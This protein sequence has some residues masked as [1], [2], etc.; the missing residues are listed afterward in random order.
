MSD[1]AIPPSPRPDLLL[2]S[3][4]EL[5]AE[6]MI[7][8]RDVARRLVEDDGVVVGT[9]DDG[10]PRPLELDPLPLV[11]GAAE[12]SLLE[13]GLE[14]RAVLLDALLAD[15]YGDRALV[16][17]GLVPAELVIGHPGFLPQADGIPTRHKLFLT[18]ADLGRAAD[19]SWRV[20][21]DRTQAPVGAGYAMATRRII[22]RTL[23]APHRENDL[24]RLRGF[25]DV[26]RAGFLEAASDVV[27]APRV[28]LLASPESAESA[29]D[30]VITATLLGFPLVGAEDLA[31]RR[32]RLWLNTT[33]KPEPVDVV[34]RRV[35]ATVSD[36]L[37]LTGGGGGVPGLVE[38]TR[39]G[40]VT[41]VNPIGAGVLENPALAAYLP[42]IAES[43]LG[44]ELLLP[45]VGTWWCGDPAS[46]AYVRDHLDEPGEL[47][48]R[49]VAGQEGGARVRPAA[50]AAAD[51]EALIARIDA[52]PWAWCAQEVLP[53][54]AISRVTD[55][56]LEQ[57]PALLR[58]FTLAGPR[59]ATTMPGGLARLAPETSPVPTLA[60][61]VAKDVW[62]LRDD[63]AESAEGTPSASD[64]AE[65]TRIVVAMPRDGRP[66]T[67]LPLPPQAAEDLYWFGRY[68]ERAEST[69]R[70]LLVADD[71]VED[72]LRRRG[73]AGHVAMR[74]LIDAIDGVTSVHRDR[75]STPE[76]AD[77]AR[78]WS[79]GA[80]LPHLRGL[81]F[82]ARRRGTVRY[83]ARRAARAAA[84]VRE[85]LSGDT[86]LVLSRLERTLGTPKSIGDDL[87]SVLASVVESLLAL[88]GIAA[89]GLVRDASW[90]FFDAGR[91]VERSQETVRVLRATVTTP[92]PP[93]ADRLV[94]EA[95][96]SSRESIIS[97][98]RRLVEG[99]PRRLPLAVALDLLLTDPTNPR[100]VR[101]QLDRLREDLRHAPAPAVFAALDEVDAH[102]TAADWASTLDDR[103]QLADDLQTLE[104]GLRD[105][106]AA[107]DR[108][109]LRHRA[110][111]VV[112]EGPR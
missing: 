27:E 45:S 92:R 13:K 81:V 26:M 38:A 59:G 73:T 71:L 91:R 95:V 108:D 47:E 42:G 15:L 82:D 109:V 48:L 72:H 24:R 110:P 69:A 32:G 34:V 37:D 19:G 17:G 85:L 112:Q 46:W 67:G 52:Q 44:E 105:L 28:V 1:S 89:E 58:T 101:F 100:A 12:W 2:P 94:L 11:L 9:D 79:S 53:D 7:G 30:E 66:V 99:P 60:Q 20:V 8:R 104:R 33:E 93:K 65:A 75:R 97:H 41:V 56:G 76:T 86:W 83:S 50:L 102:L 84:Q 36:P 40:A 51:R 6:E 80:P 111:P 77:T 25:F 4:E 39:R 18:A 90:A 103:E 21:A 54:W 31:M 106:S 62:V 74:A 22:A 49:P 98:R 35:G 16:A 3:L 68:A 87:Q 70:L 23:A 43:L 29:F 88:A 78:G 57:R 61:A 63:D 55:A 14:Q 10:Q 107:L 64:E 5:T 96:L